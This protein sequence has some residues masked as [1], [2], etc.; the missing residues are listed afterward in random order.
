MR[1]VVLLLLALALVICWL[2][3]GASATGSGVYYNGTEL[4]TFPT[5]F[6]SDLPYYVVYSKT[7]DDGSVEI[8][9]TRTSHKLTLGYDSDALIYPYYLDVSPAGTT[10]SYAF[11]Q[12]SDSSWT[13]AG[14]TGIYGITSEVSTFDGNSPICWV[15]NNYQFIY[16]NYDI[17]DYNG[18]I[19][20]DWSLNGVYVPDTEVTDPTE[21]TEAT[22]DGGN[23][24]SGLA[25]NDGTNDDSVVSYNGH[26]LPNISGYLSAELPYAILFDVVGSEYEEIGA[27][28]G[29]QF[30]HGLL[31]TVYP[32]IYDFD[33][34]YIELRPVDYSAC[35]LY[36]YDPVTAKWYDMFGLVTDGEISGIFI[37]EE[38]GLDIVPFERFIWANYNVFY[39]A[40][41]LLHDLLDEKLGLVLDQQELM[42]FYLEII[43]A[44]SSGN[45][46][47]VEESLDGIQD[48]IDGVGDQIAG[49][50]DQISE[51]NDLLGDIS[52]GITS[53]PNKIME[54]ITGLFVPSE[55]EMADIKDK[56]EQLL[57]DRFGAVYE[58]IAIIDNWASAFTEQGIQ[59]T[60]TF[61]S[62]TIPLGEADF[63]FGGWEVDVVPEGFEFLIEI[64]KKFISIVCTFAFVNGMKARYERVLEGRD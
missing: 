46:D 6:E 34:G 42:V 37:D 61:P 7:S 52:E 33:T 51:G 15:G 48:S 38:S 62:I 54:G 22:P 28:Y 56:W 59:D 53:L 25:D 4:P 24:D 64:L 23:T 26:M 41:M 50:N 17:F 36:C 57:S 60:I 10:L 40:F 18:D 30:T 29:Y 14:V 12:L 55:E 27:M 58:S 21:S 49:V 13:Y 3:V 2:P 31:L 1:R 39:D 44:N 20:Y 5:E 63:V 47:S 16:A 45:W 35:I 43:S 9:F 19:W 11:L 8:H 32:L